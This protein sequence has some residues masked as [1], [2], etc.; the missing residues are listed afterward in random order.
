MC[1]ALALLEKENEVKEKMAAVNGD[2]AQLHRVLLVKLDMVAKEKSMARFLA[3]NPTR[4]S[5]K[6][7]IAKRTIRT[8]K[9]RKTKRDL[10][11]IP[12]EVFQIRPS[13]ENQNRKS[14]SLRGICLHWTTV[15][16][17]MIKSG[18]VYRIMVTNPW[19]VGIGGLA[20]SFATMLG[21]RAISPDK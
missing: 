18:F 10:F 4:A 15:D 1:L 6:G 11:R 5:A 7:K 17:Q 13:N 12:K 8:P 21:T 9:P 14:R 3:S 16:Q 20:L 2:Q 19:V